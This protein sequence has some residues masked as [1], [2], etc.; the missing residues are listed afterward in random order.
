MYTAGIASLS[1][2]P[3]AARKAATKDDEDDTE[4]APASTPKA[5]AADE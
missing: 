3:A 5:K 1:N 4:P 2:N